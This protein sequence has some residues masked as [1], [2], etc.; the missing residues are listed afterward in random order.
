MNLNINFIQRT[1]LDIYMYMYIY[2]DAEIIFSDTNFM[3]GAWLG[4][5]RATLLWFWE[6]GTL[7]GLTGF[8]DWDPFEAI[9]AQPCAG[10]RNNKWISFDS[11]DSNGIICEKRQ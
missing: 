2:T 10:I 3:D 4:V 11:D 7:L 5:Y 9:S 6:D 1:E 8:S